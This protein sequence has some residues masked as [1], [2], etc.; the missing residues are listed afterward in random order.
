MNNASVRLLAIESSCDDTSAAVLRDGRILSNIIS[1]QAIHA[2]YGGIVPEVASRMHQENITIVV[3][4]ALKKAVVG[5]KE[6]DAIACTA[7]PGLLGS[8]TVGISFAK[9]LALS[10]DIPFISINHMKAHVLSHFIDDPKP[11]FPFLCLTVSGGHTQIVLVKDYDDMEVL[12]QTRDDAAGE[13]FDKSG[14]ILGLS[15]PAGP[16]IDRLASLGN[17][18]YPFPIP[19]IDG[20]DFSFSGL[21]TAIMYFIRDEVKKNP[22][23]IPQHLNDICASIQ[24]TIVEI[25]TRKILAASKKYGINEIGIAGGV[26][27]NS[28]LRKRLT[29]LGKEQQWNLYFPALQYCT[30]NAGMIAIAGYYQFLEGNFSSLD[31]APFVRGVE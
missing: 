6:I 9:A 1:S 25:L 18:V 31:T 21:K 14:K 29:E 10:L 20:L 16:E 30:D 22:D 4:A 2:Q 7:G 5:L 3:D 15:Y 28:G 11:A 19:Q 27:A 26:A 8:L 17:T 13:A 12:G 23:F 24:H